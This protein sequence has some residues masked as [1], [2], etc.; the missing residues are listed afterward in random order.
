MSQ[1]TPGSP[2][3]GSMIA[4]VA[5]LLGGLILLALATSDLDFGPTRIDRSGRLSIHIN[6]VS[7]RMA[8]DVFLPTRGWVLQPR[9]LDLPVQESPEDL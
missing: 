7:Q 4:I 1:S 2:I 9:F 3:S 5:G 6:G 8:R